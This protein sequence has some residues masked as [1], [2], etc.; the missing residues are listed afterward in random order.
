MLKKKIFFEP[1]AQKK[2]KNWKGG[3]GG[4]KWSEK[5]YF[6][7]PLLHIIKNHFSTDIYRPMQNKWLQK[8]FFVLPVCLYLFIYFTVHLKLT[9]LNMVEI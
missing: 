7:R 9:S 3:G 1:P 5:L 6:W 4:G 2:K 8:L